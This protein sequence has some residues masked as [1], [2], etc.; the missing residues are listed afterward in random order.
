MPAGKP[1]IAIT[2]GDPAGIG[3]EIL[4][5]TLA[6]PRV[7]ER[8]RPIVIG[9]PWALEQGADI[10]GVGLDVRSLDAP[11][12]ATETCAGIAQV[13]DPSDVAANEIALGQISAASGRASVAF[14]ETAARLA[15]AHE[16]DAMVTCPINKESVHAAGF[17][18]DIGHQE[19]LA[20]LTKAELTA[21]MLMTPGLRVAHLSTHKSLIEA[22]RYVTTDT[23][24][25]KLRLTHDSLV[26]W[27]MKA[28][29]IAVAAL[30]P[31]GGE[32]G[33]LGREE[34]DEIAPAV[35]KAQAAGM[36]VSGPFPADSVFYRAIAGAFDAVLA[37]YHDQ[38]HIAIKVHN[39]EDSVTV[40]MGIPF[41]RT[42]V[43]H[44]T[45]FDIAGKGIANH[46]GLGRAVDTAITLANGE[47]GRS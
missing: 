45:A 11:E 10:A 35:A 40:T 34:I 12:H 6:E 46:Q 28:P 16:V 2:M 31:H 1:T 47:L 29:R 24:L 27:G 19:I 30:N 43:D 21:T 41:I 13:L 15:M 44:G 20:R 5:K 42:S 25:A 36:D 33:L 4:A 18:G 9:N 17:V 38:G 22:C 7:H 23:I 26:E 39:F 14:V 3:P 32:G 8:A 37:L